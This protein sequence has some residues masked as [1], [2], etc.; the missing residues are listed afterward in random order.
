M[1][2]RRNSRMSVS[3]T[4]PRFSLISDPDAS[5]SYASQA[6][7]KPLLVLTPAPLQRMWKT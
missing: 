4:Q 2:R 5:R 6:A 1:A 7:L 3:E